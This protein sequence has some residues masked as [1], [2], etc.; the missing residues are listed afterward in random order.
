MEILEI[1]AWYWVVG[2]LVV[3]LLLLRWIM[4]YKSEFN[5]V[6]LFWIALFFA[7][8]GTAGFA[9]WAPLALVAELQGMQ[10]D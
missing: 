3:G 4:S 2:V 9:L 5:V 10:F 7:I 8:I 6:R 1:D